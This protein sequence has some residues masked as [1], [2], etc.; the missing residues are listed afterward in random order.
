MTE[1]SQDIRCQ[2]WEYLATPQDFRVVERGDLRPE[3]ERVTVSR[4]GLSLE[5][6][7]TGVSAQRTK[8]EAAPPAGTIRT[9]FPQVKVEDEHTRSKGSCST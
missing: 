6:S 3:I 8:K 4:D 2:E 5:L 1:P 9:T 7:A